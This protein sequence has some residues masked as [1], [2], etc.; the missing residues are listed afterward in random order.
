MNSQNVI[1][2]K[3]ELPLGIMVY[4]FPS[5]VS[6]FFL[7]LCKSKWMH[8]L[9]EMFLFSLRKEFTERYFYIVIW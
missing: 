6:D 7:L 5:H 1:D 3:D 2:S 9:M 4:D 8:V